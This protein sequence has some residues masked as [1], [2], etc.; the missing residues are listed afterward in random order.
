M[1]NSL[2]NQSNSRILSEIIIP[3]DHDI[4]G[5]AQYRELCLQSKLIPCSYFMAH[6]QEKEMILRYHQFSTDDIRVIAK[7]LCV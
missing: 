5:R 1:K 7:I 2:T 4:S 6:I 3:E